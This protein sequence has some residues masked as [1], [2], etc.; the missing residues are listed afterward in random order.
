[1]RWKARGAGTYARIFNP[2]RL[3]LAAMTSQMPIR[4]WANLPEAPLIPAL[5]LDA[6]GRTGAMIAVLPRAG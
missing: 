3:R 2:A 1:M 6:G 4:S 5:V